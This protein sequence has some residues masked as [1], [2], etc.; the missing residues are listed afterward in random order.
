MLVLYVFLER[1]LSGD[2]Y[3]NGVYRGFFRGGIWNIY[4]YLMKE[5]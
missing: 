2:G 5:G 1:S 4:F 3:L